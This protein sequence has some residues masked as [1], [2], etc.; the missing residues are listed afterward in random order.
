M[1][2][3]PGGTAG[4]VP[5][6]TRLGATVAGGA[7]PIPGSLADGRR[8]GWETSR[9]PLA[10]PHRQGCRHRRVAPLRVSA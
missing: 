7:G 9:L 6:A 4:E 2:P 3:D 8:L 10:R 1:I 5:D